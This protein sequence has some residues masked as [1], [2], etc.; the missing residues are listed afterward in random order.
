MSGGHFDYDQYRIRTI[1][2]AIQFEL[3]KWD[4]DG[5]TFDFTVRTAQTFQDAIALLRVAE[6]Y[7][8]RIDWFLSGDDTEEG[9]HARLLDE[10]ERVY[11]YTQTINGIKFPEPEKDDGRV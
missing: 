9:F 11:R 3:E 2:D 10:L 8:Q 7:A 5:G 4:R 1:A 6:V